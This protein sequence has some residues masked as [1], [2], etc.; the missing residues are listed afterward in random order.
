MELR[1]IVSIC[2]SNHGIGESTRSSDMF[3]DESSWA[4]A[5]NDANDDIDSVWGFNAISSKVTCPSYIYVVSSSFLVLLH[6][7]IIGA[8][9][10]LVLAFS[11][12]IST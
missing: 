9:A 8:R 5:F 2:C 7:T 3:G 4:A 1:L 10:C 6:V 11:G 12:F